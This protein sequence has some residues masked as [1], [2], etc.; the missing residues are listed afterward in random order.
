MDGLT[1]A[2]VT[3]RL[4]GHWSYRCLTYMAGFAIQGR[5][6][7]CIWVAAAVP[8]VL[9]SWGSSGVIAGSSEGHWDACQWG[10][11]GT[12]TEDSFFKRYSR[13][14]KDSRV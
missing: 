11:R 4:P 2:M 10:P 9:V 7:G 13:G 14:A 8:F 1:L 6:T 5:G 12:K 3:P